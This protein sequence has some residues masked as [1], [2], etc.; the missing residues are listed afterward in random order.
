MTYQTQAQIP[1]FDF[2]TIWD[3]TIRSALVSCPYKWAWE[4]GACRVPD[5]ATSIH[6]HFGGCYASGLEAWRKAFWEDPSPDREAY[7]IAEGLKALITAWGDYEA[8]EGVKNLESLVAA[9]ESYTREYPPLADHLKPMKTSEGRHEA[10]EFSFA[11]PLEDI[12]HPTTGEPIIYA[13]RFD[14]IC[15]YNKALYV[16]DDKTTTRL[17]PSWYR[18]WDMRGQFLGYIYAARRFDMP[19]AGAAIRGTAIKKSGIEH[20]E[21]IFQ[22]PEWKVEEWRTVLT[23]DITR[24]IGL[25]K[26]WYFPKN[27]GE[28]CQAYGGCSMKPI[29]NTPNPGRW[30]EIYT[31]ERKWNPLEIEA[32]ATSS[33]IPVPNQSGEHHES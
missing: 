14:M 5:T 22:I 13:G 16:L 11:I 10:A 32:P 23:Y 1:R 24:A 20:A 29:C 9:Y 3:S 7:A 25:W 26:S 2:P 33:H 27:F 6:L 28:S 18:Q 21:V 4:Y 30:A 15:E 17:G 19:V 31:K 12:L 8:P